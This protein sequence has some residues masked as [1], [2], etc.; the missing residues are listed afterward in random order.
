METNFIQTLIGVL[1]LTAF[2]FIVSKWILFIILSPI[3]KNLSLKQGRRKAT[4]KNSDNP[5]RDT[6]KKPTAR[7]VRTVFIKYLYGYM[8]YM[9]I[10]TGQ[11]PSHHIR[12]WIYKNI[13]KVKV[14]K[15]VVIYYGAEIRNHNKLIIEKGAIIG[16]KCILDARNGIEIQKN[17]CLATGVQIWS[18]QH[19]HRDSWFRCISDESYK[20]IIGK[21]AWIGPRSIIL[22]SVKIG[23]GAVVAAGSVVTKDIPPFTIVGGI[24]AKEIG[25][26][27]DKLYYGFNGDYSPFL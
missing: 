10:K 19:A 26:R 3:I 18:E 4:S 1:G 15:D 24:P 23:E 20:V 2:L 9:D 6:L 27:N 12:I 14:S 7:L 8:R 22:H 16:D 5:S 17:A 25:K 13:F 21:R 11:I